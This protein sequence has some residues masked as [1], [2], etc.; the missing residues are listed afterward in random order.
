MTRRA[1]KLE[2]VAVG[3]TMAGLVLA[4]IIAL[5]VFGS[6]PFAQGP[7]DVILAA[8][9]DG[10]T[11]DGEPVSVEAAAPAVEA[12]LRARPDARLVLAGRLDGDLGRVMAAL[13]A[14]S[15]GREAS[16]P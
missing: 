8:S 16:P 10:L 15:A 11:L 3:T 1:E 2:L 12:A 14:R 4:G 7:G 6:A 13:G 5:Y 9:V